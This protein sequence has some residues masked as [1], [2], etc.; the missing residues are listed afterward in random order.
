M[1]PAKQQQPLET[2]SRLVPHQQHHSSVPFALSVDTQS[3]RSCW[4]PS[5]SRQNFFAPFFTI[6]LI[7]LSPPCF[8]ASW[9]AF[10]LSDLTNP[11]RFTFH[12][13]IRMLLIVQHLWLSQKAARSSSIPLIA[14]ASVALCHLPWKELTSHPAAEGPSAVFRHMAPRPSTLSHEKYQDNQTCLPVIHA[15][16]CLGFPLFECCNT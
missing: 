4:L 13:P 5:P 6:T 1:R 14:G 2:E 9:G 8:P 7:Y 11:S 10:T 16:I 15:T 3:H 12:P